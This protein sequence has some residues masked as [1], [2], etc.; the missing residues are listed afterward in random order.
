MATITLG[1]NV[2]D[3][4][5]TN[6]YSIGTISPTAGELLVCIIGTTDTEDAAASIGNNGSMTFTKVSAVAKNNGDY[7]YVFIS[8]QGAPGGSVQFSADFG[9][10]RSSCQ[11]TI[12]RIS[13]MTNFGSAA[14]RG[15]GSTVGGINTLPN[16]TL[17]ATSLTTNP[18]IFITASQS[19]P[20]NLSAPSGFTEYVDQ[21]NNAPNAGQFVSGINSGMTATN[22]ST[23]TLSA[24]T[25]GALVI[26]LDASGAAVEP[27]TVIWITED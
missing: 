17:P 15:Q 10:N 14:V 27:T 25:W 24:T 13:G 3:S 21:G 6:S 26:E 7:F 8:N 9:S 16:A 4:S 22:V 19:N 20:A 23:G 18:V 12:L 2:A 11:M 1:T 5:N